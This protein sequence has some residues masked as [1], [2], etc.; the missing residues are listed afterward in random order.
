MVFFTAWIYEPSIDKGIKY[1]EETEKH[2]VEFDLCFGEA[3]DVVE[4]APIGE[5]DE[6]EGSY[7]RG[8]LQMMERK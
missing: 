1:Q 5:H 8:R 4:G 2:K 3:K 6:G 7:V